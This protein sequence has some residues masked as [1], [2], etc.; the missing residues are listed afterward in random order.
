M[1]K[2][3]YIL[4]IV[5]VSASIIL[6]SSLGVRH[7]FGL[8]L[9]PISDFPE[10]GRET[11]GLA[12]ALNHLMIG[13]FSPVFGGM[14]DKYGTGKTACFGILLTTVGLFWLAS[15]NSSF[16]VIGAQTLV[17]MGMAGS[18]TAVILGAVGKV[19]SDD[20]RSTAI[21]VAM[22]SGSFGQFLFVPIG[23][24]LIMEL[25]WSVTLYWF[26]TAALFITLFA[27]GLSLGSR[28]K[29]N[30]NF[31]KQSLKQALI[32]A[33]QS[34]SYILLTIGFFVC[35]FHVT[36]VATHLPAYLSDASMPT[37]VGGW[38]LALIGLFNIVGTLGSGYLGDKLSKKYLLTLLY[39]LRS[40]LFLL[41]IILP[42]NPFTAL[43]FS[44]LLGI[45]W[46]STVPLTSGLIATFFG[47]A[48]MSMLY[49]FTFFSHQVGSF[50]GS[51]LGGKLYDYFGS[52]D[53]MW[54]SC[55][56]LGF[57]AAAFHYPIKE[58]PFAKLQS[59]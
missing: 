17:G 40:V 4:P 53:L 30:E 47:T 58:R 23:N 10:V 13:V 29:I 20:K 36:F 27:S 39:S 51:W 35:G 8:F 24:F 7:A 14:S 1:I 16:D 11:F 26:T 18:G 22:A 54:W 42:Q 2:Q 50:L 43:M 3:K 48:Y 25:G 55:V 46:L 5:L 15:T 32:T 49:G 31:Q 41:F 28:I 33:F 52:Y 44:A 21:G 19:V 12:V 34:R 37:W 59:A 57:I 56:L 6:A 45:L 9:L 38:A